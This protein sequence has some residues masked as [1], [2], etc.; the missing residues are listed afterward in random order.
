MTMV[1][2]ML[3]SLN[4][5][6]MASTAAWSA[7]FSSPRPITRAEAMAAASVS[8]TASSPMFLSI[9]VPLRPEVA[10]ALASARGV[11]S[12]QEQV[13]SPRRP[14]LRPH[15]DVHGMPDRH[16]RLVR[17]AMHLVLEPDLHP[18]MRLREMDE[19]HVVVLRRLDVLHR[20]FDHRPE[21]RAVLDLGV[22]QPQPADEMAAGALEEAQVVR[23]VHDAHLVGIAVDDADAV[24]LHAASSIIARRDR[25]PA[26]SAFVPAGDP[27]GPP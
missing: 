15:A 18:G 23:V 26:A 25:R 1:P 14:H 6:R 21:D 24:G 9:V 2:R 10:G 7:S 16:Q 3:S 17:L 22:G 13:G 11:E 4:A 5:L 20:R 12:L 8:R 19:E 27:G